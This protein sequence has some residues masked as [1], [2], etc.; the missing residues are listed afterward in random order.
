MF[1]NFWIT[2]TTMHEMNPE[3]RSFSLF[4]TT[5]LLLLLLS[6][7][8]IFLSLVYYKKLNETQKQKFRIILSILIIADEFFKYGSTIFTNQWEWG[9]LPLH[10][11]SINIIV[12][13]IYTV[14][15]NDIVA[16]LLYTT[17]L[18][19]ALLALITP[20]WN[21]IPIVSA[22][23]LHSGSIHMLLVLYAL[24]ILVDGYK[25][26]F[27]NLPKV[28][29][30]LLLECIPIYFINRI[31]NTNFF[32][33]SHTDGNPILGFLA[34]ILG[35]KWFFLGLPVIATFVWIFM[36]LPWEISRRKSKTIS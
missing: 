11:C 17:C 28:Y 21:D 1:D 15:K 35:D 12:S 33:L 31:L 25:P 30:V 23:G 7:A 13:T 5:H 32:F 4:G 36:Y 27:R 6:A 2:R 34:S 14:K 8:I 3:Y 24:T 9:F 29:L 26:N 22:M 18:P 19:G 20:T 16:E 10:L